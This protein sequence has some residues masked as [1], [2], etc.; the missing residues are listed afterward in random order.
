MCV[1]ARE[2]PHNVSQ[3]V[4]CSWSGQRASPAAAAIYLPAAAE[5]LFA[6]PPQTSDVLVSIPGDRLVLKQTVG[7]WGACVMRLTIT[8]SKQILYGPMLGLLQRQSV[9]RGAPLLATG[10]VQATEVIVLRVWTLTW[11]QPGACRHGRCIKSDPGL[12][13]FAQKNLSNSPLSTLPSSVVGI[14][15]K[16]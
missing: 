1:R 15:P 9:W 16:R 8:P 3:C 10:S 5:R 7:F 11:A 2:V 14:T 12:N 13:S 4:P 6:G